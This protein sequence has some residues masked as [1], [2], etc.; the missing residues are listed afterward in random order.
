MK[1]AVIAP[2]EIPAR[3]ANTIQVM[4]MAQAMVISGHEVF[5]LAPRTPKTT[6]EPDSQIGDLENASGEPWEDLAWHYGLKTKFP[7]IRLI[8]RPGLRRYDFSLSAVRW[9]RRWNA[10]LVYTRLPQAAALAVMLGSKT[11][12]E[13]HDMPQGFAGPI[14]FRLYLMSASACRLVCITSALAND[15]QNQYGESRISSRLIIAPDGVDIERYETLPSPQQ[16]RSII[17]NKLR[18]R[19]PRDLVRFTAG[20]TGHLY[21]GRGVDFMLELAGT[22]PKIDFL[23][24]GGEIRDIS[25]LETEISRQNLENIFVAGFIPNAEL[26][27]FQSACDVLLMPYQNLVAASSGG[28]I[29]RYLSPMKLFEYLAC[30]RPIVSSTLS[31]LSEVLNNQNAVLL[32]AGNVESWTLALRQLQNDPETRERLSTQAR[33]DALKYTWEKRVGLILEETE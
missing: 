25:E 16:A 33:Q 11:I 17:N 10:E 1:I 28:D 30:G 2:S 18:G 19:F 21:P 12:L 8:S 5:V 22:L 23:L 3:R 9:A 29:S 6:R 24:V 15:L 27:L 14:L 31:V 4:K 26:P 7:I 13:V 32:P 20:Y